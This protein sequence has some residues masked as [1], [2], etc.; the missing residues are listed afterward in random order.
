MCYTSIAVGYALLIQCGTFRDDSREYWQDAEELRR[1]HWNKPD[2]QNHNIATYYEWRR[3]AAYRCGQADVLEFCVLALLVLGIAPLAIPKVVE[4]IRN[5]YS[6]DL[7]D[8]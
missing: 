7:F 2:P 5:Y 1:T 6:E 4:W 8:E 3:A